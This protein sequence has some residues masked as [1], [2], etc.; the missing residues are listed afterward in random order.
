MRGDEE[1]GAIVTAEGVKKEGTSGDGNTNA[2]RE[3][4]AGEFGAGESGRVGECGEHGKTMLEVH[5][6]PSRMHRA[7]QWSTM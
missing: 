2:G 7:Q 3:S 6:A 4:D 5:Q 1:M